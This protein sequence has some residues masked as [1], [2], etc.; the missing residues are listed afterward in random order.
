MTA[1]EGVGGWLGPRPEVRIA[2]P[3]PPPDREEGW[4]VVGM[5]WDGMSADPYIQAAAKYESCP[6]VTVGCHSNNKLRARVRVR[7]ML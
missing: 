4:W 1:G 3:P 2:P 5:G 6:L 7:P